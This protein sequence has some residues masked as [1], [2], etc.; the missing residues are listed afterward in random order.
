M[1]GEHVGVRLFGAPQAVTD[2][3]AAAWPRAVLHRDD[4]AAG[5][6]AAIVWQAAEDAVLAF[7]AAHPEC[8]WLHT[9]AAG[10]PAGLLRWAERRSLVVT[11]G[12]GTHGR[13]VAEHVLALLLAHYKR[14]PEL[15]DDQRAR[16]WRPR[17]AAELYGR[18]A[19]VIGLGDL[20]RTTATLLSAFGVRVTGYRRTG[21]AVPEV[22]AVF[23]PGR[24][25]EFLSGLDILVLAAP[26]TPSTRSLIGA[27]QLALLNPGAVLVNVGRGPVVDEA[28]LLAALRSGQLSGAALDVFDTEPLPRSSQLW[29]QP[30]VLVSPHSADVT[31]PTDTR[32]LD[33]IVD[34]VGRFRSGAALRNVVDPARGY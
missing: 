26:L 5:C 12:S 15:L 20:G 23:G 19:G 27:R 21:E 34:N 6:R 16:R 31:A 29:T 8:V 33:L 10:V 13:A 3:I 11:N 32:S 1:A 25:A 22:D 28:A 7:L 18:R 30:G 4:T 2:R 9:T 14:L 24:L 17:V